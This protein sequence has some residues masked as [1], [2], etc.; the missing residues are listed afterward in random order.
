MKKKQ[1]S[2]RIGLSE[3]TTL[4]RVQK[5]IYIGVCLTK[6]LKTATDEFQNLTEGIKGIPKVAV[7]ILQAY[8]GCSLKV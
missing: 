2:E 7:H 8:S 6:N 4:V 1:L 5:R 3:G